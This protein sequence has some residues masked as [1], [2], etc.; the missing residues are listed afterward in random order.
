V[1]VEEHERGGA[2]HAG[3]GFAVGVGGAFDALGAVGVA[4]GGAAAGAVGVRRWA[5]AE[6]GGV[7]VGECV[8]GGK[9]E[10]ECGESERGSSPPLR[11]TS[12]WKGEE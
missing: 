12:P 4:R 7:A 8:A 1:G 11:G 5:G 9:R 2:A 6:V 10:E 3:G